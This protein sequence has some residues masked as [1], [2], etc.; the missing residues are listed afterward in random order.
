MVKIIKALPKF[1]YPES[2]MKSLRN[3]WEMNEADCVGYSVLTANIM[4]LL[5]R[6]FIYNSSITFLE[7]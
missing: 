7:G 1:K 6:P 3:I 4:K 2:R 5:G